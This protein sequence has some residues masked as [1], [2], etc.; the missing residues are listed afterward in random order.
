M[1]GLVP[2][3]LAIIVGAIFIFSL[4]TD[5]YMNEVFACM[6]LVNTPALQDRSSK[7]KGISH[8]LKIASEAHGLI[9]ASYCKPAIA[10]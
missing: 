10:G 6:Y 1:D 9:G 8:D 4:K 3:L 2:L 7:P 5:I